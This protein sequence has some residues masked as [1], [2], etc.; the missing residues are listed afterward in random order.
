MNSARDSNF[1]LNFWIPI[2]VTVS[3]HLIIGTYILLNLIDIAIIQWIRRYMEYFSFGFK[4]NSRFLQKWKLIKDLLFT[5]YRVI[6][7]PLMLHL[8]H[9]LLVFVQSSPP[10]PPLWSKNVTVEVAATAIIESWFWS[11]WTWTW[12][13]H[14]IFAFTIERKSH[15][16]AS[17]L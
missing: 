16:S 17:S 15:S 13:F 8:S 9:D 14:T 11:R 10:S 12:D 6:K 2:H 5:Y 3:C 1:N 7:I 4:V